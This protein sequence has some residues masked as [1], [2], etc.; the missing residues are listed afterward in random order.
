MAKKLHKIRRTSGLPF[1]GSDIDAMHQAIAAN[2]DKVVKKV[3]WDGSSVP[4]KHVFERSDRLLKRTEAIVRRRFPLEG[5]VAL[6][7]TEKQA[8]AFVQTY[9]T[10]LI[11]L[12]E[13][14]EL[15]LYILDSA[16]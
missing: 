14:G 10:L 7:S 1:L 5:L 13:Q 6:P 12:N 15:Q 8:Q 9:G 2:F 16:V 11:T 4:E 3:G